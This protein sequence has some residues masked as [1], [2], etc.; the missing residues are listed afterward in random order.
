MEVPQGEA[1]AC[2]SLSS[3]G[4]SHPPL[5][6]QFP[7]FALMMPTFLSPGPAFPLTFPLHQTS[8][9]VSPRLLTPTGSHTG[10]C[11]FLL[12]PCQSRPATPTPDPSPHPS[13]VFTVT[14]ST[15][16][17]MIALF[18]AMSQA[19]A[20][21]QDVINMSNEWINKWSKW[22]WNNILTVENPLTTHNVP[23]AVL[24]ALPIFKGS[25]FSLPVSGCTGL[26]TQAL[27]KLRFKS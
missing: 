23:C 14:G 24:T 12:S 4:P 19:L 9:W 27:E 13:L 21:R 1:Q 5:Q 6:P 8:P 3:K 18:T 22:V 10:L 7:R 25:V 2:S 16:Q 15:A 17:F 11:H 20:P 26:S